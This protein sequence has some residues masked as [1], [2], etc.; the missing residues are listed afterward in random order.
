MTPV[1]F[2]AI[3]LI[4]IG[5]TLL[6]CGII[7]FFRQWHRIRK[8]IRTEGEVI[9]LITS[10]QHGEYIRVKT[11]D[12]VKLEQKQMYRP[13]IQFR[14]QR[15]RKVKFRASV[16]MRPSPY[17]VGDRVSVLYLPDDP[18]GAQIDR[19]VYLWFYVIMLV[20]FGCLTIG[21]GLMIWVLQ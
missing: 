19:F 1:P 4:L 21:M 17:Q 2:R 20:L 7:L 12:G 13:I 18:K 14:T 15:G 3:V 8:S 16:S 9:D 6:V 11:L 10:K 5:V